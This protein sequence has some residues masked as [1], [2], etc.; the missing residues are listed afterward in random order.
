MASMLFSLRPVDVP[1]LGTMAVD[2]T[3]RLYIDFGAAA[4]ETIQFNSDGLLHEC[5]HLFADHGARGRDMN[6]AP[7]EKTMSN[8]CADAEINDDLRDAGCDMSRDVL[9]ESIGQPDYGTYEE[10]LVALRKHRAAQPKKPKPAKGQPGDGDGQP[11]QSDGKGKRQDTG[12]GKGQGEGKG[13]PRA[14]LGCGSGSGGKAHPCELGEDDDLGGHAPAATGAERERVLIATAASIR[15]YEASGQGSVPAGLLSKANFVLAPPK[16]SWQKKLAYVTRRAVAQR[17]GQSDVTFNR[18]HRR[19]R[20][21]GLIHPGTFSPTP[22]VVVI[23]DTSG[24]MDLKDLNETTNE[25]VGISKRLSIRGDDLRIIDCDA[26]AYA[27]KEFEGV[28]TLHDVAGRGGT[29]MTAGIEAAMALKDKP[30]VI[31]VMTDGGTGWPSER[32]GIPVVACIVG[33]GN[34]HTAKNVPDW[35]TTVVTC[36]L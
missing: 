11:G 13:K 31:V 30:S 2:Y 4:D 28:V 26:I 6:V 17:P 25:I 32:T 34:A 24:S 35:M 21:P 16:V 7:D 36:D 8:L 1:G 19:Y 18:R 9:P 12:Q 27:A 22:R 10:Y 5:G 29:S 23:R 14:I 33:K 3:H 15:E 20:T